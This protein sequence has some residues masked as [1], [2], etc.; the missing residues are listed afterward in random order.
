MCMLAQMRSYLNH[1]AFGTTIRENPSL[2]NT[3]PV[4]SFPG[5]DSFQDIGPP[6]GYSF[7]DLLASNSS[8]ESQRIAEAFLVAIEQAF[9][10]DQRVTTSGASDE[11]AAQEDF[12]P[13]NHPEPAVDEVKA[14]KECV[15]FCLF[16]PLFPIFVSV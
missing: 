4:I 2:D 7:E 16:F 9:P 10:E 6:P 8:E 15:K 14:Q 1:V 11:H 3:K 13:E 5:S 12:H